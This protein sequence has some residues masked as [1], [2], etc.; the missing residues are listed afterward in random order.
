MPNFQ[1]IRQNHLLA[2]FYASFR[3][4]AYSGSLADLELLVGCPFCPY[5]PHFGLIKLGEP[6]RQI[7]E[8][9]IPTYNHGFLRG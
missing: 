3:S 5:F 4:F 7:S 2:T 8:I 6:S 1:L 9:L